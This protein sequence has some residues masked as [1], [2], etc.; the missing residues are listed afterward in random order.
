MNSH[1]QL[2][3]FPTMAIF[4]VLPLAVI[5]MSSSRI[6]YLPI[7]F[8]LSPEDGKYWLRIRKKADVPTAAELLDFLY[9]KFEVGIEG[10]I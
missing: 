1:P 10:K 3:K 4:K 2:Q 6:S 5:K 9:D 8:S 7:H